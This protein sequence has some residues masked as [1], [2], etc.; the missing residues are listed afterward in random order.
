MTFLRQPRLYAPLLAI[1]AL[2]IAGLWLVTSSSASPIPTVTTDKAAYF[3]E[4]TV[5]ISGTGFDP[6]TAY[7]VAVT[8]GD[9]TMVH[10]DGSF[11]PGW[12]TIT[13]DGLGNFL[14]S[15]QLDGVSGVY[16]VD[17]YT[18][19][20]AGPGSADPVLA[21]TTFT[22]DTPSATAL[23]AAYNANT[24]V[25]T[26]SGTY[27]WGPCPQAGK[28]VGFAIFINGATP[29]SPGTGA[30]DGSG[31]VNTMHPAN[32][33]SYVT[34]A[35]TGSWGPDSHTLASAPTS[36][37]VVMYDVHSDVMPPKTG[38]HSTVGAGSNRNDD[39]SY[40][41]NSPTN[42]YSSLS[43]KAPTNTK[44]FTVNKNFSDSSAASVTVS[45]TCTNGGVPSPAS[46]LVSHA[47]PR[48]F[49]ITGFTAGATC[50]ATE[51]VPAGYTANQA[52]CAGVAIST[53]GTASCT[54]TNTRTTSTLTVTKIYSPSGP[55]TS[56]NVSVSS[57][58]SGTPSPTSGQ[59]GTT[60]GTAFTTTISGFNAGATCVVT[61]SPVPSGYSMT[62]TTCNPVSITAGT[63]SC[64]ITNTLNSATFTVNKDF[65]DKPSTDTTTVS[66][67]LNCGGVGTIVANP[68][69]AS[70]AAAA[71]FTVTGIPS[72]A[73]CTASESPVPSGYTSSGC[74]TGVALA[75]NGSATC[76]ITNT[77][78]STLTVNKVC[79]PTTDSGLFK[80][81]ITPGPTSADKPCGGTTGAVQLSPGA[82]NVSE[83]AGAGTNLANYSTVIDG[84]CSGAGAITLAAG[85]V[86][87]CTITNT[88]QPTLTV[89]KVC[90]PTTDSGLFKLVITPGPTSADKPCGGTTGAVQL[91]PGAYNVSELAGAGT[92]LANYSTVIDG[93]CS[94]D[95]SSP[96]R[97]RRQ[98]PAPSP[99]P[100][101]PPLTVNKVCVPTTD[102]GM[103]NLLIDAGTDVGRRPLQRHHR[104]RALSTGAH[105]V[106]E[107]AGA[108][109]NLA[110]YTRSPTAPVPPTAQSP[111]P[112][113]ERQDLHH[114]QHPPAHPDRQQ[115]LRPDHGHRHVQPR[116]RRRHHVGRRPLR[117][118][119]RDRLVPAPAP[120]TSVSRPAPA[121]TWP[122]HIGHRRRLRRR[123][124]H[125]PGRRP[126]RHL[127]HHQHPHASTLTVNK[128]CVP[129]T[130]TG[131]V[132]PR[133]DL[134]T[135]TANA[136]RHRHRGR[137][138]GAPAPTPSVRLAGR[139]QLWPTTRASSAAPAPADGTI[140]LAAG[141]NAD[142]HD[143]QQP[144]AHADRKQ[145]LRPDDGH[146]PL[147]PRDRPPARRRP[148]ACG[149][150]TGAVHGRHR[151][152]H[153]Q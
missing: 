55:T 7:D 67:T 34:C 120:T 39:N 130:D 57:C 3:P 88:R 25:L 54:I 48:N 103:F 56:V 93:A 99:T 153:R 29:V 26:T 77:L 51:A 113:A 132:Q 85:D 131:H 41:K 128:V 37:C 70:E 83:L 11:I 138:G 114:H 79:V 63:S 58:T 49:T 14:Y 145:G 119:H 73:S 60:A 47:A 127:H 2:L 31:A 13:T 12:D 53:S 129:T 125:H 96:C 147:Q 97:R 124:H 101:S 150:G 21:E 64:T 74:T 4:E 9:G 15:Y 108:G 117:Q 100:A 59:A 89:N 36:V 95:G 111:W 62:A 149:G 106:S 134:G 136:L 142:L 50:T 43:C 133:D 80:L 94:G 69:N 20:W 75:A 68:K 19:P 33:S 72:S 35:A 30:L 10:G 1:L 65:S 126:E 98:D 44:T 121:P 45:V 81:V 105:T 16:T 5:Q 139:H 22:D 116:D 17:V 38:S 82:Y 87:T 104:C 115:G 102:T 152:P 140:T 107:P 84:A 76:T 112:P 109:T 78:N 123:R 137:R 40:E 146:R 71:V 27:S 135:T 52:G 90:V 143:H 24:G 151:R 18:S 6:N 144:P 148:T 8:R 141:Q 110:N 66:V 118:H 46:G 23:T 122:T 86:K 91:S 42:S 32:M 28:F 92:N 61:E